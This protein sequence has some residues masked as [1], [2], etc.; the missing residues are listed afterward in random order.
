MIELKKTTF[1]DPTT[2]GES[3]T[4]LY[5][6]WSDIKKRCTNPNCKSFPYYG[7][8]GISL[9]PAWSN[10]FTA[11]RDWAR[12]A[13]YQDNLT[14]ERRDT[15]AGYSSKNCHWIPKSEQWRTKRNTATVV[16]RGNEIAIVDLAAIHGLPVKT[17]R[18]RLFLLGWNIED[19]VSRPRR[20]L[21][22]KPTVQYL[23]Q[24]VM[25]GRSA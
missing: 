12:A 15:N 5:K 22:P 8:R 17:L 13:G 24:I 18:S 16:F 1:F 10:D 23:N 11:F 21:F 20:R 4:R 7:G 6:I 9:D 25:R 3:R 19:A 14:I 2:H